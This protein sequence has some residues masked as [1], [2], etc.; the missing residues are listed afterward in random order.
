[1]GF[2]ESPKYQAAGKRLPD[3]LRPAYKE[4]VKHYS[5]LT[6]IRYGRSYIAYELLADLVL[7]G[8]RLSATAHP[9]SK[10]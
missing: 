8:W 6:E 9:D 3:E 1:M 5:F 7:A 2:E 10:I 4:L